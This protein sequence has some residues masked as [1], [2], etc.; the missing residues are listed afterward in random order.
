MT[1]IG[2]AIPDRVPSP[3][4]E[5]Y[6]Q[7]AQIT[8]MVHIPVCLN[9]S[10]QTPRTRS[11]RHPDVEE[12]SRPKPQTTRTVG[13]EPRRPNVTLSEFDESKGLSEQPRITQMN[14]GPSAMI[15]SSAGRAIDRATP[16]ATREAILRAIVRA[17]VRATG[18]TTWRATGRAT[19]A[20]MVG[21]TDRATGRATERTT[22]KVT[23][24][25]TRQAT[26]RAAGTAVRQAT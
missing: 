19:P 24:R 8:P 6:P 20:A 17:T 11:Y 13:Q 2:P 26:R 10:P 7:I 25:A 4:G 21:A 23:R 22:G 12:G 18:R 5:D 9:P 3:T 1:G 15:V 16:R 14:A